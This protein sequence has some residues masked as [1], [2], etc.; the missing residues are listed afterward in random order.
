MEDHVCLTCGQLCDCRLGDTLCLCCAWEEE[1][2]YWHLPLIVALLALLLGGCTPFVSELSD[3]SGCLISEGGPIPGVSSGKVL[4]CRSGKD[5]AR[6][7]FKDAERSIV[8][9]HRK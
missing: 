1:K 2:T 7:E 3:S 8:I 4:V 9:E 6:V 5:R